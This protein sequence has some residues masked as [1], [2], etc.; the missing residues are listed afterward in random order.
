MHTVPGEGSS[1]AMPAMSQPCQRRGLGGTSSWVVTRNFVAAVVSAMQNK[2]FCL[3]E[4][5]YILI[6][7]P[8]KTQISCDSFFSM[9]GR[10]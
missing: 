4:T 3:P 5:L 7:S 8:R 1:N 9:Y 10:H 2:A 6:P